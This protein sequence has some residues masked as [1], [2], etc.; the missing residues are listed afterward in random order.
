M[1]KT[2]EELKL[3]SKEDYVEFECEVCKEIPEL[4]KLGLPTPRIKIKKDV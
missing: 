4:K 2:I 3:F 1:I